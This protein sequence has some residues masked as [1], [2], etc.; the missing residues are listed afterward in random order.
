VKI[1]HA[2]IFVRPLKAGGQFALCTKAE[3][4]LRGPKTPLSGAPVHPKGPLHAKS[5]RPRPKA[6]SGGHV[7]AKKHL[8]QGLRE[9][10]AAL[11]LR[12][13]GRPPRR[14]WLSGW[15]NALLALGWPAKAVLLAKRKASLRCPY[16]PKAGLWEGDGVRQVSRCSVVPRVGRFFLLPPS[17]TYPSR[18]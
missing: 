3:V 5:P 10:P 13:K 9:G 8:S 14:G 7:M 17:L 4:A 15:P 18:V 2:G 6:P 16:G 1:L 12:P 11:S